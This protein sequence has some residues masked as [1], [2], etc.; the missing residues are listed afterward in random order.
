[1][2]FTTKLRH[3]V[4]FVAAAGAAC[5]IRFARHRSEPWCTIR[6]AKKE[7]DQLLS[8]VTQANHNNRISHKRHSQRPESGKHARRQRVRAS[9]SMSFRVRGREFTN[10]RGLLARLLQVVD[11][12]VTAEDLRDRR[13]MNRLGPKTCLLYTSPSPRDRG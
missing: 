3:A 6:S 4:G 9:V 13:I 7:F 11:L 8:A 12:G 2:T 5:A 10:K 1:M